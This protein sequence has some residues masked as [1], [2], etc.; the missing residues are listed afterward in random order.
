MNVDIELVC[1]YFRHIKQHALAVDAMN[2]NG[3]IKAAALVHIPFSIKN[4]ITEAGLQAVGHVAVAF[5]YLD[6]FLV[7]DIS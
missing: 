4:T 6:T 5:V 1:N 2:F 3:C 7:V